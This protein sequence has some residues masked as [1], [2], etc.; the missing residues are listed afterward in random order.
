MSK[1][2]TKPADETESAPQEDHIAG[3]DSVQMAE[4]LRTNRQ[5]QRSNQLLLDG[6]IIG[7]LFSPESHF[8]QLDGQPVQIIVT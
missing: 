2:S 4:K 1:R 5:H 7:A 6:P 8:Y 3:L